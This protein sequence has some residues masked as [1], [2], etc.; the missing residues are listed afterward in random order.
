MEQV[1]NKR[2]ARC[3]Y[4]CGAE[5]E[6]SPELPFFT[7]RAA[8]SSEAEES[9]KNCK[10]K[11]AAHSRET[12]ARNKTLKCHNFEPHGEFETD[13]FYCGCRGWD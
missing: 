10:Y 5:V 6:S 11:K 2:V 12:M 4:G 8:G 1:T 13:Q 3:V 9:C 7:S